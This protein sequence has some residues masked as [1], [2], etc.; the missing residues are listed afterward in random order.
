M[1][2][3]V[4]ENMHANK[5]TYRKALYNYDENTSTSLYQSFRIQGKKE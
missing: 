5:Y 1:M 3:V 2:K 4:F